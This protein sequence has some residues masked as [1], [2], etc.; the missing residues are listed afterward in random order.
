MR[1]VESLDERRWNSILQDTVQYTAFA[2]KA[3]TS[4]ANNA[5]DDFDDP[6]DI[7]M[8]APPSGMYFILSFLHYANGY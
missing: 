4:A 3:S 6:D 1:G 2:P 8:Q 7:R 5:A